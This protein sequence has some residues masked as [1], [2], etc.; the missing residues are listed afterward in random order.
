MRVAGR[1]GSVRMNDVMNEGGA[2][3][4]CVMNGSLSSAIHSPSPGNAGESRGFIGAGGQP[5]SGSVND[6]LPPPRFNASM[7]RAASSAPLSEETLCFRVGQDL[8]AL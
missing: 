5:I 1:F 8:E 7:S 2:P 4:V 6:T 3:G